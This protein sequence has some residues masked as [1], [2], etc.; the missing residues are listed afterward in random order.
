MIQ[1]TVAEM[2]KGAAFKK[3]LGVVSSFDSVGGFAGVALMGYLR[4]QDGNYNNATSLLLGVCMGAFVLAIV[5]RQLR[6]KTPV[7]L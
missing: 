7:M 2:Y 6:K 3:T 5:L 1:L 4:T